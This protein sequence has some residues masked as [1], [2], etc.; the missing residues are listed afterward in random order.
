MKV[1]GAPAL[2]I[3]GAMGIA[4]AAKNIDELNEDRFYRQLTDEA[5][6]LIIARPT[7][8]NLVWGINH[9]MSLVRR[10]GNRGIE[11]VKKALADEI[12][13]L[14]ADDLKRNEA[15]AKHGAKLVKDGAGRYRKVT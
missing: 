12:P 14:V 9:M 4:L 6:K 2:G 5:R 10:T 3:A 7:A 13:K 8:V 15:I 1:R 11:A